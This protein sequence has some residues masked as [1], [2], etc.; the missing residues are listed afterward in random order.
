MKQ[1]YEEEKS[2]NL[3]E[4][5][6]WSKSVGARSAE[7]IQREKKTMRICHNAM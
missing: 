3:L 2:E 5:I 7:K 6:C 1:M 4:Q